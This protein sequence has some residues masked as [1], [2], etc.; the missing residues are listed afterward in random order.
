[1]KV[2]KSSD[3]NPF[4]GLNFVLEEFNSLSID[5]IL[6]ENLPLLSTQTKYSWKDILYLLCI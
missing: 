1:M 2:L 6:N 4:G 3:I 5:K